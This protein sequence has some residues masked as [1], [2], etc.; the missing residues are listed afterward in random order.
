MRREPLYQRLGMIIPV[1]F[2][3]EGDPGQV[4]TL[5][6]R[7]MKDWD[8]Y[9]APERVVLVLD[10]CSWCEGS[11]RRVQENCSGEGWV[12]QVNDR[13]EGKGG[14]ALTGLKLLL[15]DPGTDWIVIRD[16]DNDHR[17]VDLPRLMER[18]QGIREATGQD[19]ILIIG[20]R[21]H[22]AFPMTF[23]RAE[24]ECITD[25]VIVSAVQWALGRSG[26]WPDWSFCDFSSPLP[27]DFLSGYKL[28]SK[29]AAVV[30]E[31]ELREQAHQQADCEPMRYGWE[32]GV[33]LSVLLAGGTIGEIQ[34]LT[35]RRQP[36]TGYGDRA[37]AQLYGN[38]ILYTLRRVG[39]EGLVAR[40]ILDNACRKS[41]LWTQEPFREEWVAVRRRIL[42]ALSAPD[43]LIELS[44]WFF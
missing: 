30:V 33:V 29:E 21:S 17:L 42:R 26:S 3:P 27:V 35:Y 23:A 16:C 8:L 12:V 25:E 18:G 40:R 24:W 32:C 37:S 31:Q 20:R 1:W 5:L 14:A 11:L 10:G 4:E 28:L 15:S 43:D 41:L 6:Y 38:Q 34:R 44:S 13:N 39:A 19:R 9:V 7:T 22:L 2:P 36:V